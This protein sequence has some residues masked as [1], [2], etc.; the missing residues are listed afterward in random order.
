MPSR[1][2]SPAM[3][4]ANADARGLSARLEVREDRERVQ[5][6]EIAADHV[7]H[8]RPFRFFRG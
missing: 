4:R 3:A 2:S 6:L 1:A 5:D 8:A 7:A